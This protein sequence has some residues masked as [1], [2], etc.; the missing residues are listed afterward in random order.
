MPGR[1]CSD[2]RFCFHTKA[3]NVPVQSNIFE[4]PLGC[5]HLRGVALSHV[6]HGKD[7]LL[8]ELSIVVKVDLRIKANHWDQDKEGQG[9]GNNRVRER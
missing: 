7:S 2:T 9:D 6:V 8:T 5:M 3:G 1:A 4:I